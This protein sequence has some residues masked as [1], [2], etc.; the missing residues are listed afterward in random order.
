MFTLIRDWI[1]QER[2][3]WPVI[4]CKLC[5][6]GVTIRRRTS[7][8]TERWQQHPAWT[9]TLPAS[10]VVNVSLDPGVWSYFGDHQ[11]KLTRSLRP[12]RWTAE[13]EGPGRDE[14]TRQALVEAAALVAYGR[15]PV[16]R[17][18]VARAVRPRPRTPPVVATYPGHQPDHRLS[19]GYPPGAVGI[20]GCADSPSKA[21]ARR[22][23]QSRRVTAYLG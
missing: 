17:Q 12:D 14:R 19:S 4:R 5:F 20:D 15:S 13:A 3:P 16:G 2:E 18:G 6:V 9:R 23:E 8:N 21:T 1:E 22:P 10:A 11:V 7:P